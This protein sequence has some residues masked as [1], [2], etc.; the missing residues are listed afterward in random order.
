L[1]LPQSKVYNACC[2]LGPVI[3][4]PDE[5]TN[6]YGLDMTCTIERNGV[7]VFSGR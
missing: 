6:P 5:L 2:S 1:Y 4:T 7:T 3:V